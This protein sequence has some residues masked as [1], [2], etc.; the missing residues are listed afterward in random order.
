MPLLGFPESEKERLTSWLRLPRR[1]RVAIRLLHRNL[2]HLQKEALV[3][4][5]RAARAP[6]DYINAAQS[7]R[8]QG[9]DNTEAET[10]KHT[11]CHHL[12]HQTFNHEV[13]VDV[14]EIVD[15]SGKRFSILNA[16]WMGTTYDQDLKNLREFVTERVSRPSNAFL[17]AFVLGWTRWAGW[18]W[19]VRMLQA[20]SRWI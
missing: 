14:F 6:Q 5:L 15:S 7:F 12:D 1:P 18:P 11:T 19:L 10:S 9:Y 4:R 8:C 2:R 16:V 3:Q 13:G 17:R 20:G